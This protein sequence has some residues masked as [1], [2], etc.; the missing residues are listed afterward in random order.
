MR[1]VEVEQGG[2]GEGSSI[3]I[4]MAAVKMTMAEFMIDIHFNG[5][6]YHFRAQHER[7]FIQWFKPMRASAGF[8]ESDI[9]QVGV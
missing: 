6:A 8:V 5:M 3:P 7:D 9:P 1:Q 4:K 2:P